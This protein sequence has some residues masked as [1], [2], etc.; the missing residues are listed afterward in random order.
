MDSSI[1][2][3]VAWVRSSGQTWAMV[4]LLTCLQVLTKLMKLVTLLTALKTGFLREIC[5][6]KPQ[7]YIDLTRSQ[8]FSR[9]SF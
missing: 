8:E 6:V 1:R 2:T 3:L 9:K 7:S 5:E 4:S